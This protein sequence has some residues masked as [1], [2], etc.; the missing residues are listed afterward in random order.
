MIKHFVILVLFI[1]G[2]LCSATAQDKFNPFI[3]DK[4]KRNTYTGVFEHSNRLP[5]S[6]K[7]APVHFIK[8]QGDG[9]EECDIN[10]INGSLLKEVRL[11]DSDDSTF[12]ITKSG[13]SKG[14]RI[15]QLHKIT[16]IR[17]GFWKGF[18]YGMAG[19]VV[20]WSV[21]GLLADKHGW[22]I[23]FGSGFVV[24]LIL[25]VPTGLISGMIT[26]F[27]TNDDVYSFGNINPSAKSKWLK[28]IV[29][30]HKK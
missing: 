23:N 22:S 26:E 16:F 29:S 7:K 11:I 27:A 4:M 14:F 18:G 28:K 1:S 20:F 10:L 5:L 24:G 21:Y 13:I 30:E 8:L 25:G 17:H 15:E 19:S 6:Q 9:S 3:K 12:T 2:Y